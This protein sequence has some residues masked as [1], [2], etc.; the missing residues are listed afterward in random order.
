MQKI[1]HHFTTQH[2]TFLIAICLVTMLP[3]CTDSPEA[4]RAKFSA[5]LTKETKKILPKRVDDVTQLVGIT[6]E[7]DVLIYQYKVTGLG[8]AQIDQSQ[9]KTALKTMLVQQI[10]NHPKKE[11][12]LKL[13]FSLRHV[14]RVEPSGEEI[15]IEIP[16]SE[17]P[18]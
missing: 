8:T 17:I 1:I 12:F 13:G 7:D 18:K 10:G 2:C 6:A 16:H 5:Q 4:R 11:E 14:Y 15:V 9:F 3:G